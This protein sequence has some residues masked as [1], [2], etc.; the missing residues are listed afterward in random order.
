MKK[1]VALLLALCMV[2]SLAACSSKTSAEPTQ[3]AASNTPAETKA[4]AE[5]SAEP[6]T[7][8]V[9]IPPITT[10]YADQMNGWIKEFNEI[11]PHLTIEVI[12]TSWD[13]N[14]EKLTTT[15][16][17]GQAPDIGNVDAS[18]LGTYVDM[19]VAISLNEYMSAETLADYDDAALA[20]TTLDNTIYG[21]PLYVSIQ[22]LG[23]NK[24][25]LEA[26]GVDVEK[27]QT[28]GWTFDEF[29]TAIAN[30]TTDDCYGFVF[31]NAGICTSDFIN[32][33]GTSAGLSSAFT[34]ELKYAYTSE[35]MY[36]LLTSIEEIISAGYMPNYGVEAGTR[37]V[38]LETGECMVTGK[39]MPLFENNVNKNNAGIA[40]GTAV[41]G[42]VEV[43]YVFL[44]CPTMENVTE[45]VY[46]AANAFI[47]MKNQNTTD[48]HLANVMLFLD[49]ISSGE[50]AAVTAN[51]CYLSCVC[52]TGREAQ[53]SMELDQ[54]AANAASAARAVSLVAAPPSGVTSEQSSHA[55]TMMDEVVV[56]KMQALIAGEITADAMFEAIRSEAFAL[57]GEEN[58]E[59]GFI[60]G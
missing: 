28:E 55:N 19:G 6:D 41:E 7:I 15:A 39:A 49:F 44:P 27:V 47:A 3:A 10:D 16:L 59:T 8:V 53:A 23:G 37:L 5:P 9:M 24:A 25:M 34:P 12:A 50:R 35:N 46:G 2:L 56:P 33:F 54:S 17:S 60:G 38:M 48:E 22:G 40:D 4:P 11:Y 20:Y 14:V 42:S 13:D 1:I 52:E 29:M 57:F 18:T 43:E 51:S 36:N 58:C 21:L 26:A 32:I 30:G 31:A 45:G